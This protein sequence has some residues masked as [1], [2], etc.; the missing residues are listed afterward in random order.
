MYSPRLRVT[1]R[2]L[3]DDL[4][5]SAEH[6]RRDARQYCAEHEALRSF[7]VKRE[8]AP[9]VG[10]QVKGIEPFGRYIS[11]H[12]TRGRGVTFWDEAED[13]C[14]LLAYSDTHASGED[15]DCYRYF[16]RLGERDELLPTEDDYELIWDV[17][18][19]SVLDALAEMGKDMYAEARESGGEVNRSYLH[20]SALMLVD[21]LVI[22]SSG[23]EQG[24][25]SVSLPADITVGPDVVIDYMARLLPE[26]VDL[27][28]L[29]QSSH[30][31]DRLCR[32]DELVWTWTAYELPI[33]DSE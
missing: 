10:E 9:G 1:R 21:L 30:F 23:N 26:H 25:L 28:T 19:E 22:D 3:I 33:E 16:M 13:T 24:W 29:E 17:S 27:D 14:W 15:R 6:A 32:Y 2:C 8:S 11:L 12:V 5:L 4:G 31:G 18:A 20:A 7:V